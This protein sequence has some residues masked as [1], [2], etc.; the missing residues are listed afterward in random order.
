[1]RAKRSSADVAVLARQVAAAA[2]EVLPGCDRRLCERL[3][4][5]SDPAHD[6]D[7][8]VDL[9]SEDMADWPTDAWL[10]VDDYHLLRESTDAEEFVEGIVQRSQVQLL[11]ATRDRPSWVSTRDVLY[12]EVLEIGQSLLA[13]SEDEVEELLSGSQDKISSGL[14]ALAGGW[15]AVIGLASLTTTESILPVDG[16]ELPEQLYEFFAEEVY[17]ALEPESRIALGLLATAP[18]LDRELATEL[19][20][21]GR[22]E[23]V[24]AE[25]LT[26]GVLEERGGKLD[27]HPLARA[28]LGERA[29]R[30][31]T[32]EFNDALATAA[33]VYRARREWDAA[34]DVACQRGLVDLEPLMEDALDELLNSARLA[35]LITWVTRA[36]QRGLNFPSLLIA[37]AEVNLRHGLHTSAEA[38]ARRAVDGPW[39]GSDV[40]YRALELAGRAAHVGSREE[41]A[42]DLF[43]RAG[44]VAPDPVRRRKAMWGQVMS[45]AALELPEAHD[46][47][48]DLENISLGHNP[49]ELVRLVDRQ[50]SL[51]YRFGFVRHLRDARRVAELVPLV[52][53]PFAR[54]SFRSVYGWGLTLGSFYGEA[55]EQSQLLLEEATE[56]RVDV[57][58]SYAHAMLGYSLAGLK[59]FDEAHEELRLAGVAARAMNDPFGDHNAYALTVR[60]ML[61][62]GRAAEAC[63]VEP[64]DGTDS[65]KGMRGEVLASRALALATLGRM[66]D[67][68]ASGR[69]AASLTQGVETR[70]LWPAVR[71]VV[72][73]KSR[74][75]GFMENAA[76]LVNVAFDAGGVDLLV[77][78]YRANPELLSTLLSSPECVERTIY[79]IS[80]AGDKDIAGSAGQ[81]I[82]TSLDPRSSLSPREREV[83]EL[84]CAGLSNREI[85]Q[86]LFI[87]EGTV[88]VHVHNMFDKVGIRSRTALAVNA[89][90]ERNR[91]AT[92]TI[93]PG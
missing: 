91:H 17:R 41:E 84:V 4:A 26:L 68:L 25:A 56:Y 19:L 18:S 39:T 34:F 71:A 87:S 82:A 24:C 29:R 45:A 7:V 46:L 57:A 72:A 74:D 69:E 63:A 88:K 54:C 76:E 44:E 52:E 3:K 90:H 55:H 75:S 77:C 53:D 11:I 33:T 42:L 2:A 28:F 1:M 9:L 58:V 67:A 93:E 61:Q 50:L 10:I 62:E 80:R 6:L 86:R 92:S 21:S 49:A 31:T 16:L 23:R 79:A 40:G 5:T 36:T 73:L 59:L 85:A 83:Y 60:V 47:L 81:E 89:A 15:P 38:M 51:G 12:G 22:A 70:V 13:M 14:L 27:L 20:G 43:R 48:K 35:T 66:G 65:I 64:P 30:E 8:L 78:A 37:Q 32:T